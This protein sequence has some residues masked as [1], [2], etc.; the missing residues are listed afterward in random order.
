MCIDIISSHSKKWN[1]FHYDF[2]YMG[3]FL[4]TK[5]VK[6]ILF[7]FWLKQIRNSHI[8]CFSQFLHGIHSRRNSFTFNALQRRF[9]DTAWF[10]QLFQ[11]DLSFCPGFQ[12]KNFHPFA[13]PLDF[14][15][16][17]IITILD[18]KKRG[19]FILYTH[20]E[21]FFNNQNAYIGFNNY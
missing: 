11:R 6:N 9:A 12:K 1:I 13:L 17:L 14:N 4:S 21:Y 2:P 15:F 16:D 7:K 10:R 3:N 20:R 19:F 18:E 5:I 8:H